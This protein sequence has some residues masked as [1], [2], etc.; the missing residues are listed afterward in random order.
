[1]RGRD[2]FSNAMRTIRRRRIG[3]DDAER[4]LATGRIPAHPGLSQL[5][6][7]AAAPPQASELAGLPGAVAAFEEAARLDRPVAVSRRRRVLRPLAAAGAVAAMLAGGV[8][9]AAETGNLPGRP[10]PDRTTVT[11]APP[12]ATRPAPSRGPGR[13][14]AAAPQPPSGRPDRTLSPTSPAVTGLCRAWDA[15]RRNP[16]GPPMAA[17]ALRE[18]AVAAGGESRIP[19]FCAAL[20]AASHPPTPSRPAGKGPAKPARPTAKKG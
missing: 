1:M 17:G 11:S 20:P 8:A 10:V 19:A 18:L 2:A 5:L 7:A 3:P 15:Q 13:T 9:V 6:T 4:L 12:E 16:H 14:P